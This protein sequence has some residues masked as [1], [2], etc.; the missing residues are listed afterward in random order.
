MECHAISS[1]MI[2][3]FIISVIL[4]TA[5]MKEAVGSLEKSLKSSFLRGISRCNEDTQM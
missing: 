3:E 1:G 4:S 2:Q 5:L